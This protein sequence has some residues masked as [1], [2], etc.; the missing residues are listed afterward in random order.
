M[1]KIHGV[2]WD[3]FDS[4]TSLKTPLTKSNFL[5]NLDKIEISTTL[6]SVDNKT[7]KQEKLKAFVE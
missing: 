2:N 6:S 3:H 5:F 4:Q 7:Q 1:L